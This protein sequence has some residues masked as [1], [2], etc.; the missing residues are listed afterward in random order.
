MTTTGGGRRPT[1]KLT[2][3]FILRTLKRVDMIA[4][5][6]DSKH[7]AK[8]LVDRGELN[9]LRVP[10][11]LSDIWQCARSY[12]KELGRDVY[13]E[14]HP[15]RNCLA[16]GEKIDSDS[17][18]TIYCKRKCRQRA[19]RVR[20]AEAA[21]RNSPLP[22]RRSLFEQETALRLKRLQRAKKHITGEQS[23]VSSDAGELSNVTGQPP[24]G[25]EKP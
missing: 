4:A 3:Q 19:Y 23:D 22:K 20:K 16:C 13:D 2:W 25:G 7:I 1:K 9:R 8:R 21:G 17:N 18:K 6:Y 14:D 15:N 24:L 12:L 10:E 5:R 11:Y